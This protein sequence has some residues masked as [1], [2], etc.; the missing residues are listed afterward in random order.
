M[1][2]ITVNARL[3]VPGEPFEPSAP[4]IVVTR[5]G[6]EGTVSD[7]EI[8]LDADPPSFDP[9]LE[10]EAQ[11]YADGDYEAVVDGT[12]EVILVKVEGGELKQP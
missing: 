10:G 1:S 5:H 7:V 4:Y 8:A 12:S 9:Y 3:R 6:P 11:G 2:T